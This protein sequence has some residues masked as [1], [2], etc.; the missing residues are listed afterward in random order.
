MVDRKLQISPAGLRG[1]YV[2]AILVGCNFVLHGLAPLFNY[3]LNLYLCP[4][5]PLV[6]I[7]VEIFY[8]TDGGADLHVNVAAIA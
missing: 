7:F 6:N 8:R 3:A 4:I 5:W 1:G 2:S